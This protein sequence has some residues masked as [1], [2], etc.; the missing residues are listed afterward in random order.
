MKDNKIWKIIFMLSIAG[1][2]FG[3][4]LI[5]SGCAGG[6]SGDSGET[7]PEAPTNLEAVSVAT[8]QVNLTWIDNSNNESG[9]KIERKIGDSGSWSE[10]VTVGANEEAYQDTGLTSGT[11]Y[12]YRV[13]AYNDA[14]NSEYSLEASAITLTRSTFTFGSDAI[15]TTQTIGVNGGTLEGP[16]DSPLEGVVVNLSAGALQEDT[17]ISLGYNTGTMAPASGQ[18]SSTSI[19]L[20]SSGSTTFEQ[21]V[22]ITVPFAQDE[23]ILVPYLIDN[24]GYL[25]AITL[26]QIDRQNN[27]ATFQTFHASLFSWVLELLGFGESDSYDTGYTP[28]ADGFQIVN[29][30]STYNRD[31]ECFGMTSFSLWYFINH[32]S[33]GDFYDKYMTAVGVDSAGTNVFGQNIIA[34]R[35]FIS[36]AQQWNSYI[37]TVAAQQNLTKE[38]QFTVINNAL[39]NTANPLLIYLYHDQ[40]AGTGAHSVLAYAYNDSII[41][42]YDP[43]HPNTVKTITYNITDESWDDYSGY[44][45]IIYNGDGSLNLT[46]SYSNI[47]NDAE[48][49][50]N[51]SADAIITINSHN[52]G[53]DVPSPGTTISGIVTSGL[54]LVT[55]LE[56]FVNS[57]SFKADVDLDGLFNIGISLQYGVNHVQFVT[58][59]NDASGNLIVLPNDMATVDFTLNGTF[60]IS[61]ILVTLTWDKNDTDVDLYV[62]NP[63]GD[64]SCYYHRL[65]EA[66]GELDYDDTNGYGPEHWTLERSDTTYYNQDYDVRI[67]YYSDHGN[68]PTNYTVTIM[69]YESTDREIAYT[70]RGNLATSNSSNND[71][72]DTGSDWRDIGTIQ[73]TQEGLT[74]IGA[75]SLLDPS[76]RPRI[77]IAVPVLPESER[78]KF[79][80]KK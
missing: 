72:L 25:H 40:T 13:R 80:L 1:M 62:I 19:V 44:D 54:V 29:R 38:E 43:N 49:D 2:C 45:G 74:S 76:G 78:I 15:L 50:F 65:T 57:T 9:F 59:G 22:T 48:N 8:S 56:V 11:K 61:I 39:L 60:D 26:T 47:I 10:I 42:I 3:L 73:L 51:S 12:Y 67:H 52:N 41:S 79:K 23:N 21:P 35:S 4:A 58:R 17:E 16:S 5:T 24:D 37:P 36:I 71:P 6:D 18:A 77:Q 28:G 30:G 69:L 7:T 63:V 14:G 27:T 75:K 20:S 70:F 66:G 46:E 68:G 33:M 55:Q 32:L 34:T 64:Y 53:D 31:G